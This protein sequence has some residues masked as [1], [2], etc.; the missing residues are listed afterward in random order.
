MILLNI[1]I[2]NLSNVYN[3]AQIMYGLWDKIRKDIALTNHN[4][5][6]KKIIN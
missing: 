6:Q 1:M 5:H 2:N 3:S 4:V